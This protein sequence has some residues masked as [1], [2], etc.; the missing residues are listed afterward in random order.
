MYMLNAPV[1]CAQSEATLEAISQHS[2]RLCIGQKV[3]ICST[4]TLVRSS[5][6]QVNELVL[7]HCKS[8]PSRRYGLAQITNRL[9]A[10][11]E[12]EATQQT[13]AVYCV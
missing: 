3:V 12:E 1:V 9:H 8:E 7:W 2:L 11:L 4:S 13:G 10:V 6:H 5:S